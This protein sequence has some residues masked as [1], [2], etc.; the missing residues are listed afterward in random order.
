[1]RKGPLACDRA[2]KS[3]NE[4]LRKGS[5]YGTDNVSSSAELLLLLVLSTM[6][7]AACSLW[8]AVLSALRRDSSSPSG[9]PSCPPPG[10]PG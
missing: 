1:M 10:D 7:S 9:V 5:S 4:K 6:F 3:V 8:T 2:E